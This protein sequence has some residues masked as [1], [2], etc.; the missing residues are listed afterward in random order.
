MPL[1]SA[2]SASARRSVTSVASR[3][4]GCSSASVRCA[5]SDVAKRLA[6]SSPLLSPSI[7]PAWASDSTSSPISAP[8][9]GKSRRSSAITWASGGVP[10]C[11]AKAKPHQ[12][13]PWQIFRSRLFVPGC[14]GSTSRS[15]PRRHGRA[16][17][18]ASRRR[19]LS[20]TVM[21]SSLP[22]STGNAWATGLT[23]SRKR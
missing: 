1:R 18:F 17:R 12:R 14:S 5:C 16:T 9:S 13:L 15:S 23:I 19:L 3:S 10:G 6:L 4:S 2:S 20:Q 21:V 8:C 7:R 11:A 22:S